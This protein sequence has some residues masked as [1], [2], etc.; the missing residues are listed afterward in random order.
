MW[1]MRPRPRRRRMGE[2]LINRLLRSNT[3]RRG[4]GIGMKGGVVVE[5]IGTVEGTEVVGGVI[6]V[7][8]GTIGIGMMIAVEAR[9]GTEMT[10]GTMDTGDAQGVVLAV[11][12]TGQGV[13]VVRQGG[14]ATTTGDVEAI[15]MIVT[16]TGT[17]V[18]IAMVDAMADVIMMHV[19]TGEHRL[20]CV[21]RVWIGMS[22]SN[23]LSVMG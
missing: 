4:G 1:M 16:M 21:H 18:I 10:T 19:G 3:L 12:G 7:I 13:A 20:D 15:E 5:E 17:T 8:G 9:Q 23:D 14:I 2:S 22:E 11:L 6:T